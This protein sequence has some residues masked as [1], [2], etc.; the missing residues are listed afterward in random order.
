[1]KE[2]G[3]GRKSFLEAVR[4][5]VLSGFMSRVRLPTSSTLLH[6]FSTWDPCPPGA[7]LPRMQR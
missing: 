1:M 7:G 6:A 4:L 2:E 5:P 3:C